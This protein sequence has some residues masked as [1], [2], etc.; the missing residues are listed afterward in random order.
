MKRTLILLLV[1][2]LAFGSIAV[3]EAK[4][5]K[6]VKRVERVVEV[7]YDAPA[8]GIGAASTGACLAATNS[9]GLVAIGPDDKFMKVEITD[10]SGTTTQVSLGQDTD[11]ATPGTEVDLG[12]ICGASTDPI[13]IEAA[14]VPITTFPWA[15]GGPDCAAVGTTG[16]IK[17]TFSN[18]P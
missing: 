6:K 3:A 14:G 15:I 9:C 1:L 12:T 13:A 7:T 8:I 16:T 11:E 5:K 4:K 18:L 10:Q 2:G 17:F